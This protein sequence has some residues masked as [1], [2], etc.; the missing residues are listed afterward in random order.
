M[1]NCFILANLNDKEFITFLGYSKEGEIFGNRIPSQMVAYYLFENNGKDIVFV[2]DQ[3]NVGGIYANHEKIIT[4]FKDVTGELLEEMIQYKIFT[5]C[6]IIIRLTFSRSSSVSTPIA[7]LS[8]I[9]IPILYP[10]SRI[11]NCSSFSVV[12]R[13]DGVSPEYISR[14]SLLKQYMPTWM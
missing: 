12:S 3:W 2:G 1:G 13:V 7:A 14:K 11:L 9:T 10:F 4:E 5:E 8:V 6:Y